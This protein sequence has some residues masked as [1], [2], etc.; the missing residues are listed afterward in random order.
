MKKIIYYAGFMFLLI[1]TSVNAQ[2]A[3]NNKNNQKLVKT[4]FLVKGMSCQGCVN[5]VKNVLKKIDGMTKIDVN[6]KEKEATVIYDPAKT[7]P[8]SIKSEFSNLPY[9][10]TEKKLL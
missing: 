8:K 3:K 7:N 2:S 9:Q 4:T 1:L 10:I 6:L 5:T